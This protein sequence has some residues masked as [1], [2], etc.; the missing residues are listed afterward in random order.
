MMFN[1]KQSR[2][3]MSKETKK[4]TTQE[5]E[6]EYIK[7]SVASDIGKGNFAACIV[8]MDKGQY[9]KTIASRTFTN[10]PKGFD[11]FFE[12]VQGKCK[13]S[14]P[15]VFTMEATGIYHEKLAWFLH[16][17]GLYVSVVLPNKAKKYMQGLG[18]KS[19][20][21]K[22][23]AAGLSRM[24]AEQKLD[25]WKAPKESI[26]ELRDITR[27]REGLQKSRTV[28]NNQLLSHLCSEFVNETVVK[29]LKEL[30]ALLDE[31]IK[32]SEKIM[33]EKLNS[34]PEI[35]EGV[36]RIIGIK[37]VSTVTIATI[38]AETNCFLSFENQRQL[39][40]FAGYDVKENQSGKHVGK[41]KISKKGNAHIRRI[42]HLPA[43]N[44]VSYDEP[45]FVNLYE[46]VYERTKIKMKGYVAVQRKLLCLIYTLWTNQVEYDRGFYKK[47]GEHPEMQGRSLSFRMV[48]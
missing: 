44:V 9:I 33:A 42:L 26:M 22:I 46:R 10:S 19:K 23:D 6:K 14:I 12:W 25:R 5:V 8:I 38:L 48:S 15:V 21:D 30:I 47:A 17:K 27:H 41:T 2:I 37:G 3:T 11:N 4:R 1:L 18:L 40:S 39:V 29:G 31:Q 28:F 35:K 16:R 32:M 7:Y 24:G 13:L 43:F 20:T 36:G 34:D 45:V